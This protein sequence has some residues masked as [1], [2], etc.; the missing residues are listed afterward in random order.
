MPEP[1]REETDRMPGQVVLEFG[2]DWCPHC[3]AI[4]PFMADMLA[5]HPQVRHIGVEDGRGKPLGRSFRVKLWPTL[6][7]LRD[8]AVVSQLVRPASDEIA[9]GFAELTAAGATKAGER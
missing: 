8:G 1:T 6:V 4:Q 2:A 9:K 5:S 3:Q 7:F